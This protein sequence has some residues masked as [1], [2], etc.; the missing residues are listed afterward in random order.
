[1]RRAMVAAVGA[2]L[3]LTLTGVA[4]ARSA[5]TPTG[6]G[7]AWPARLDPTAANT[8]YPDSAANYWITT[9]PAVS[10]ETLTIR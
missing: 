3:A 4:P 5:P 1:M 10:G 8:L 6:T 7:C 9:L 2:L